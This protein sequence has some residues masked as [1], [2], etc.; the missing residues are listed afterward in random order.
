MKDFNL[1]NKVNQLAKDG[2]VIYCNLYIMT[3]YN[4]HKITCVIKHKLKGYV[5]LSRMEANEPQTIYN[6]LIEFFKHA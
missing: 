2:K 4:T 3:T 6:N 5:E 1:A